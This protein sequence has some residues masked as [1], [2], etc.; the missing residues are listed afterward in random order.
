[1]CHFSNIGAWTLNRSLL[2]LG[3]MALIFSFSSLTQDQH[4]NE[5]ICFAVGTAD[6][7][8]HNRDGFGSFK[9]HCM[10]QQ[11]CITLSMAVALIL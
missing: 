3:Y 11:F 6:T 4:R 9:R 8:H 2:D 7:H 5:I 1:M 10:V